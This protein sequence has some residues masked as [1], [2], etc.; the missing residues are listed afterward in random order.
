MNIK[1]FVTIF[2]ITILLLT[3]YGCAG[4]QQILLVRPTSTNASSAK[5]LDSP[6]NAIVLHYPTLTVT[7]SGLEQL[8]QRTEFLFGEPYS[9]VLDFF[10]IIQEYLRTDNRTELA[11][12]IL[13]PTTV[14]SIDGIDMVIN[15]ESEFISYYD[16]IVTNKW[17]GVILTQNPS[18]LFINY[19]G[20]MVNR[21][22]L[23]FGPLC[24]DGSACEQK[25]YFILKITND[26]P[27]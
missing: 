6:D 4:S 19:R 18:E 9:N 11:S 10:L 3:F 13:Y 24:M 20:I 14:H 21:G 2:L 25:K 23:W 22:E 27:W 12:L 1:K 15:D 17:K 7:P 26:T 8:N 16:K 5:S